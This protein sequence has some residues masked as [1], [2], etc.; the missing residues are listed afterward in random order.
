MIDT[1][2]ELS[3]TPPT[4]VAGATAVVQRALTLAALASPL[5]P[6][7]I[8]LPSPVGIRTGFGSGVEVADSGWSEVLE[9]PL[10]APS[11][12]RRRAAQPNEESFSALLGGR[13]A[14]PISSLITLRARRDLD[15]GRIREAAIQLEAA[16][17]TARTELVGSIPPES[18]ES[19]VAHAV[20]VAAAAEAARAGDLDPEGEEVV[21]TALA[22][23][24]TAQRQALRA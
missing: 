22:R 17:N 2:S 7:A 11:R 8:E 6:G 3:D 13:I 9:V 19:L 10:S 4:A 16:I 5:A 14:I 1:V 18:L 23:L 24:E 20:A 15:S 12:R 21:A